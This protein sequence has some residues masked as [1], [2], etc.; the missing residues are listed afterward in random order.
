M[1]ILKKL[2]TPQEAIVA[3]AMGA[4]LESAE[5]IGRKVGLE[6]HE[7]VKLI[8][9]MHRKGLLNTKLA[10]DPRYALKPFVVGFYEAQVDRMDHELAHLFEHWWHEGGGEG[11]MKYG[12]AF[13]RV[14]PALGTVAEELILPYDDVVPLIDKSAHFQV[15]DCVCRK[16]QDLASKRRCDF[17]LRVCF[18]FLPESQPPDEKTITKQ[19]AFRL[20]DET[21]ELG[22]VHTVSN[23]TNGVHYVCN[24]CGCCCG[25]LRG[26][27][28]FGLENSVAKA[29]YVA[30]VDEAACTACGVCEDRCQ[31]DAIS[32]RG[33][34]AI[35][36]HQKCI[37]CGLCVSGCPS[38]AVRL[39]RRADAN[40]VHP[41]T[42]NATWGQMRLK[43]RGLA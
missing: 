21:E 38:D 43:N 31:V 29:N 20:L 37:G 41:P 9:S 12:P 22:L 2:F 26:V 30:D 16:Q 5:T 23:V 14:I 10:V 25:I 42:D 3:S 4:D 40:I 32:V 11:I 24:C 17:P 8:E 7:I 33:T 34:A 19:D 1:A 28:E 18:S 27:N 13:H 35:V 6:T 39:T 36:E 15:R